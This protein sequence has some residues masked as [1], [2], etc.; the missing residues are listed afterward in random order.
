MRSTGTHPHLLPMEDWISPSI[1]TDDHVISFSGFLSI[2]GS[3]VQRTP[4]GCPDREI[5]ARPYRAM[6]CE[7]VRA[8]IQRNSGEFAGTTMLNGRFGR[9]WSMVETWFGCPC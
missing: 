6:G 3:S 8:A 4:E 9:C 7:K 2:W 1:V 5:V